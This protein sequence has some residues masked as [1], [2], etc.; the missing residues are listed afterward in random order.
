MTS[1]YE[2][3]V[4]CI[5]VGKKDPKQLRVLGRVITIGEMGVTYEPDQRH[6]EAVCR[7]LGIQGSN[8]CATPWEKEASVSGDAAK[9][10]EKRKAARNGHDDNDDE[11]KAEEVLEE[12]QGEELAK[13]QSLSARLNYLALDRPDIQYGVKELMW[14]MS[15]P[16]I[17]DVKSLKRVARYL[18]GVS[19]LGQVF[20]WQRRPREVDVYVDR[21]R[22]MPPNA[23]VYQ[24][25]SGHLGQWHPQDLEQDTDG[26]CFIYR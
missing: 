18:I 26:D 15:K 12:L 11:N 25:R 14:K 23:K 9:S 7:D 8:S 22:G 10:R 2:C 24:W 6:A 20:H 17:E 13:Y 5:G 1:N 16:N 21:H 4:D 19:R 3:K